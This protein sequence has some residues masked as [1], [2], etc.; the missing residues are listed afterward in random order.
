M[1]RRS[2]T[3]A[4]IARSAGVSQM[5]ASRALSGRPGVS[6][7]RRAEIQRIADRLGY[8]ANRAAQKLSGGASRL[9]GVVTPQ[10]DSPF[11]SAVVAGVG[12]AA[13][14]AGY[15]MLVYSLME[16]GRPPPGGVTRL[17]EQI[18]D[19]VVALLPS[20]FDYLAALAAARVPVVM[21]DQRTP[22]ARFPSVAA[23]SYAGGRAAV[24][25]LVGLGHR[26]VA[27]VA[28]DERLASARDRRRA[29]LDVLAEAGLPRAPGLI[30]PGRFS[31]EGGR[32]AAAALLA[33]RDRPTAIFAANDHSALGVLAA[34]REAGV[35][36]PRDVSVV[37]FDD[38]PAAAHVHPSLT[39]VRQ[40][41][42]EMGAA[43]VRS[44]LSRIAGAPCAAAVTLG[45][46]LV[47]RSSTA[48][49]RR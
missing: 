22:R 41:L 8:A 38:L 5:T 20:E 42:Q 28:G 21:V 31:E 48:P 33:L 30:V 14:E 23:D 43:A 36:V 18:A 25:H 24:E 17:L 40:P 3:L 12:R 4:E 47:V 7:T 39:T 1:P 46:E 16:G 37:G 45:T 32:A 15:E 11:V 9:L 6:A 27:F 34:L 10:L 29:Y 44:L 19:G 35:R 26:R 13:R 49:P 2:T